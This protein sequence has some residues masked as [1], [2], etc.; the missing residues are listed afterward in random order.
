MFLRLKD[1]SLSQNF[2]L[3]QAFQ[4]LQYLQYYFWK[5][6]FQLWR[7]TLHPDLTR[8][9]LLNLMNSYC[10]VYLLKLKPRDP[11]Q[12]QGEDCGILLVKIQLDN[13]QTNS[14]PDQSEE[15]KETKPMR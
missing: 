5:T 12:R 1:L 3:N 11:R 7:R 14:S 15:Q 2:L 13:F 10:Y 8:C 9:L 4:S 6:P